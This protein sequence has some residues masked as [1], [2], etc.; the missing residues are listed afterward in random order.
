MII[1]LS[2]PEQVVGMLDEV[3]KNEGYAS[4]S[5]AVR[6]LIREYLGRKDRS[7]GADVKKVFV[8]SLLYEKGGNTEQRISIIRHEYEDIESNI[9]LHLDEKNCVEII[10]LKSSP[11]RIAGLLKSLRGVHAV[12][13]IKVLETVCDT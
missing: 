12:K 13:D 1:S 7:S 2:M 3:V 10:I 6:Y 4:R 9:H 11:E 8:I 5:D